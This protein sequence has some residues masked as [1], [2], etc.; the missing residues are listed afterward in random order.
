[1]CGVVVLGNEQGSLAALHLD[2]E[3]VAAL[4]AAVLSDEDVDVLLGL[5]REEEAAD[6]GAALRQLELLQQ[7]AL[8]VQEGEAAVLGER[9]ELEEGGDEDVGVR[10]GERGGPEATAELVEEAACGERYLM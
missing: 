3:L 5:A 4:A 10:G 7:L 8:L 9:A 1:M 6:L 2:D